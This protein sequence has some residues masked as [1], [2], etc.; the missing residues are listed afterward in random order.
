M[1]SKITLTAMSMALTACASNSLFVGTYTRVGI[2]VSQ[3]GAGAGIGIKNVAMTV[4]PTK[5]SGEAYDVLGTTDTDLALTNLVLHEV[6]ATGE[7]AICASGNGDVR[8]LQRQLIKGQPQPPLIFVAASS[9]SLLEVSLGD[10][11][12]PGIS[13]GY[14]RTVGIRMPIKNEKL[15]SAYAS[16][17][18]STLEKD[19]SSRA[20]KTEIE[21]TRSVY[22]FATG[23]AS[24]QMARQYVQQI[25]ND[26]NAEACPL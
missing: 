6:V 26:K 12:G 23:K 22:T 21:G 8:A 4:A 7:A 13:F 1:L 25:T 24:L 5:D 3:Q 9:W 10:A 11:T 15:G 14:K 18:I 17:S 20:R 2:D 19:H 16:V